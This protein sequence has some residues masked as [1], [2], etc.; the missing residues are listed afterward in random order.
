M[1]AK[2]IWRVFDSCNN[3]AMPRPIPVLSTD[4][5]YWYG[6]LEKKARAWEPLPKWY[7]VFNLL[8]LSML[9]NGLR[10]IGNNAI[11]N[12]IGTS[13]KSLSAIVIFITL[14]IGFGTYVKQEDLLE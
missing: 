7:A 4:I 10:R 9:F 14:Y 11:I 12:G 13:N 6:S 2:S 1:S 3:Y 8:I 5:Q